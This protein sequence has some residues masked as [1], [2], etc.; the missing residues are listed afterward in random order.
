[1]RTKFEVRFSVI[2]FTVFTGACAAD[3]V[4]KFASQD[5]KLAA[6]EEE[7]VSLLAWVV[8]GRVSVTGR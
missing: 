8:R 1:M 5:I 7:D 6:E 4:K 2:C 3:Y